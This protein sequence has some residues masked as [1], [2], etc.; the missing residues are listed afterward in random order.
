VRGYAGNR[1]EKDEEKC[2]D[3]PMANYTSHGQLCRSLF[4]LKKPCGGNLRRTVMHKSPTNT[5]ASIAG[6]HFDIAPMAA[7]VNLVLAG[8]SIHLLSVTHYYQNI[9]RHQH[10]EIG[11]NSLQQFKH[12]IKY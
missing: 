8:S 12:S 3:L 1:P 6:Y 10:P 5:I 7:E 9:N 2:R 4:G 11:K